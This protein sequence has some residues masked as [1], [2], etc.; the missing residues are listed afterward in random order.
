MD[1]LPAKTP[2]WGEIK[3]WSFGQ[4]FLLQIP[5][6]LYRQLSKKLNRFHNYPA[7]RIQP[8]FRLQA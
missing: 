7:M 2:L 8:F 1:Y 5:H 6:N 3:A 4:D